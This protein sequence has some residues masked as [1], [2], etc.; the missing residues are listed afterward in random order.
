MTT[1]RQFW[2]RIRRTPRRA[3]GRVAIL[4]RVFFRRFFDNDLVAPSGGAEQKMALV[5][6]VLIAPGLLATAPLLLKY[7]SPFITPGGRLIAGLDD[8]LACVSISMLVMAIATVVSWDALALDARDVAVLG[9]L[10]LSRRTI[11]VAKLQA[12]AVFVGSFGAAVSL[13]PTALFPPILMGTLQV[14]LPRA[15]W[16]VFVHGLVL[17]A[18]G[19]F[20]FLAVFAVRQALALVSSPAGFRRA[21]AVVQ[22]A[23]LLALVTAFLLVPVLPSASRSLHARN[24]RLPALGP[25]GWFLGMHEVLSGRVVLDS[26]GVVRP[27]GRMHVMLPRAPAD[28][29]RYLEEM[30]EFAKRARRGLAFFLFAALIGVVGYAIESR[31]LVRSLPPV[32]L[33]PGWARRGAASVA[34]AV[35]VRDPLARATF[36]FGLQALVRGPAQRLYASGGIALASAALILFVPR[37][38]MDSGLVGLGQPAPWSLGIQT[39][40]VAASVGTL[41]MVAT[42][43][44]E[45]RANWVFRLTAAE[46]GRCLAGA[47]RMAL[48][49]AAVPLVVLAPLHAI[50]WGTPLALAHLLYGGL[51]AALLVEW[52]FRDLGALPFTCAP[53]AGRS[54]TLLLEIL[55]GVVGSTVVL[56]YIEAWGS[57]SPPRAGAACAMV[58]LG[59][60]LAAVHR[61]RILRRSPT[62]VFEEPFVPQT[63]RLGISSGTD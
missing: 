19:C 45:L 27:V 60:V 47:R 54:R 15:A 23:L 48:L 49:L 31:R 1:L 51:V 17:M 50:A 61:Q 20:G 56:A 28:R 4:R 32:R 43:P 9:P 40:L 24:G 3:T 33:A 6:P 38:Q 58:G 62:L 29:A 14:S 44:A 25:P 35:I 18:S 57:A 52:T 53:D 2:R 7:M 42:V 41:R 22:P 5:Y 12:L 63:Q 13:V 34:R 11:V 21:S 36:F 37:H 26:P 46:A 55:A 39:L 30:P 16:V 8:T 59:V 10:P